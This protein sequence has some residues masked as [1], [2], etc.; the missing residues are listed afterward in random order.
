M[1]ALPESLPEPLR[2]APREPWMRGPI[3]NVHPLLTPLLYSFQ[4]A[5]EDL[6]KWAESLTPEQ[7]WATPHD[8]GSVGFHLRHIA[9]ST[10]RLMTYLQGRQL[11]PAQ[12]DALQAEHQP[13]A[14]RGALLAELEAAFKNAETVVRQLDIATLTEPRHVG[15]KR[16]PTT[17]HR[18]S[19]PH[20]R[21][22]P[23]P[24]RPSHQRRKMGRPF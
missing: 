16:H 13:G 15:R 7:L 18:P 19:G 9:G 8:F 20:R 10:D 6:A 3:P 12:L 2:E 1:P 22:H 11:S 14:T 17:R 4:Q 21:T 5:R 23:T 24:C